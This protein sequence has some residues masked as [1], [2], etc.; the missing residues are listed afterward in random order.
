MICT[1][2]VVGEGKMGTGIAHLVTDSGYRLCWL[3]SKE[4]DLEK[5]RRALERKSRRAFEAGLISAEK[6]DVQQGA[7]ITDEPGELSGCDMV[8]E[9][10]PEMAEVKRTLFE[11]LSAIVPKDCILATNTSSI[12]P[13]SIAP[14]G[15]HQTRFAGL[16]FFYPVSLKKWVEFTPVPGLQP[17]VRGAVMGFLETTGRSCLELTEQHPFLL[18]R[19]FLDVQNEA[20]RMVAAGSCSTAQ[21]DTVVKHALFPFGVFDFCDSVGIDTML[22]SV[23]NYTQGKPGSDHYRPFIV[24]LE[25]LVAEGKRG[26]KSGEGFYLYPGTGNPPALPNNAEEMAEYL[27]QTWINSSK[28]MTALAH[29]PIEDMNDAIRDYFDLEKGPFE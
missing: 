5:M 23:R 16:H 29:L 4:A 2:G 8:I 20:W 10:V 27:R 11:T 18:N 3:T 6:Y 14:Y 7:I 17:G 15:H 28:R 26:V 24:Q 21:M 19:I 12:L 1:V 13:S 25:A 22:A 9:A